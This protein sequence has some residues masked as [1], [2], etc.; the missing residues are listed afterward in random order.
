MQSSKSVYQKFEKMLIDKLNYCADKSKAPE[1][2]GSVLNAYQLT[3]KFDSFKNMGKQ[4]GFIFYVPAFLTSKIDPTTGFA[5]FLHPRYESV[6]A[7]QAFIGNFDS[8]SYNK[9]AGYFEFALDYDKFSKCNA[10]GKK[11]WTLCT[12]GNRIET[13][14]NPEKNS[15]WDNREVNLTAAFTELFNEYG[16]DINGDIKAQAVLQTERVFFGRLIKLIA[17]ILQM[18]NS[19]TGNI[20]KDYLISPVKNSKGEFYN[21]DNY[22]GIKNAALPCDADANGAY[23]IAKKGLWVIEQFKKA[24]SEDELAKVELKTTSKAEWMEYA[25]ANPSFDE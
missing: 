4:N 25:Q 16:I 14:R 8:I 19:E 13:F 12:F 2:I 17:L 1:E 18:R 5:D 15:E 20:H 6:A 10:Y 11:K 3:N 23:N 24:D 21:S 7:S 22:K 9:K